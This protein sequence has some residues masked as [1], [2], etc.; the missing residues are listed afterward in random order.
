MHALVI[1][2]RPCRQPCDEV[3]TEASHQPVRQWQ[4]MSHRCNVHRRPQIIGI[5]WSP[6]ESFESL[7]ISGPLCMVNIVTSIAA[8]L[9]DIC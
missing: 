7:W 1:T 9:R 2:M 3:L 4:G 5:L 6:V 8:L